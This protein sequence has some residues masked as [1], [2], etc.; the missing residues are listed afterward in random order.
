M[1]ARTGFHARMNF[2][3]GNKSMDAQQH[4]IERGLLTL[5]RQ[6]VGMRFR[7][8]GSGNFPPLVDDVAG[9]DE[10]FSHVEGKKYGNFHV[11]L[12]ELIP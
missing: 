11:T 6:S 7:I 10:K 2:Y 8:K 1:L 3:T 5:F 4:K 12:C 9:V